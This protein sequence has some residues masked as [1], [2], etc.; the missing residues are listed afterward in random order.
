[1]NPAE[2]IIK[3]IFGGTAN[4]AKELGEASSTISSWIKRGRIPAKKQSKVYDTAQRLKLP[5][6]H[7]DFFETVP[8][9]R[10]TFSENA[11]TT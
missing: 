7:K 9:K 5:L 11:N 1:M 2:K 3:T 4:A 10:S 8:K 6:T